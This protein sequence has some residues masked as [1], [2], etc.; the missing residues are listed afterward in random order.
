MTSNKYCPTCS[1]YDVDDLDFYEK[2]GKLGCSGIANASG[3][4]PDDCKPHCYTDRP[5]L[6]QEQQRQRLIK[7]VKLII[8]HKN[9]QEAAE[10][11][12]DHIT[13]I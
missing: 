4:F 9:I 2:Y 13:S 5:L 12:V 11:I 7:K 1:Y 3:E 10:Y 8:E 6:T